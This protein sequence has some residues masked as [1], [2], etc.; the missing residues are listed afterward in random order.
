M[1][2]ENWKTGLIFLA[3]HIRNAQGGCGLRRPLKVQVTQSCPT[4]CNSPGQN[5]GV[6]SLSPLQW[7][8]PTQESNQGLPHCRRILYQ[9]NYSEYPI[10]GSLKRSNP[11]T[12][13]ISA[14]NHNS[15]SHMYPKIRCSTMYNCQDMEAI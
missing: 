13:H 2:S 15:K 7:I 14:E 4:R 8:F 9:L 12:G 1:N 10:C 3:A 5:T 11:T 6:G